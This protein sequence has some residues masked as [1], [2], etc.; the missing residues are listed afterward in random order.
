M[1]RKD[2]ILTAFLSH[3]I[4]EKKYN[5]KKENLPSTVREGV[6]SSVPI[7]K[8]IALIVDSLEGPPITDS[9]LRNIITT[10]LDKAAI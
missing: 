7:I 4:V 5:V 9:N 6:Q 10:Y 2:E 1:A 8:C 3:P